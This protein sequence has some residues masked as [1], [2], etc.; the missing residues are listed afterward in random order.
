MWERERERCEHVKEILN[1]KN[2]DNLSLTTIYI[3]S[4]S[5]SWLMTLIFTINK[6]FTK[7]LKKGLKKDVEMS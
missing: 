6:R 5:R 2:E 3:F 1:S 7:T 4:Y